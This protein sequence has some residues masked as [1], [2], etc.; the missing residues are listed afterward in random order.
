MKRINSG[1]PP[2]R[3]DDRGGEIGPNPEEKATADV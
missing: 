2:Y 1:F 3:T